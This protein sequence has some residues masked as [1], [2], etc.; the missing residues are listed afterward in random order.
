[1]KK[2]TLSQYSATHVDYLGNTDTLI[3]KV[4]DN[5]YSFLMFNQ[6][7][8][9]CSLSNVMYMSDENGTVAKIRALKNHIIESYELKGDYFDLANSLE[10]ITLIDWKNN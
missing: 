1:M 10:E 8:L 6:H 9:A 2:Q 3:F 4:K 5:Q 7:R